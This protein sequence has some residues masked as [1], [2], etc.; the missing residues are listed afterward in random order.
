MASTGNSNNHYNNRNNNHNHNNNNRNGNAI[1][2]TSQIE[3][4]K[5]QKGNN[6][7]KYVSNCQWR[8][9]DSI[10]PDYVM[11]PSICALY[12]SVRYHK[13]NRS[14]IH[15]R[16]SKLRSKYM[17]RVLLLHIDDGENYNDDILIELNKVCCINKLT[18]ICA[19]SYLECARYIETYHY[20]K[21]KPVDCLM[22]SSYKQYVNNKRNREQNG[23]EAENKRND[24]IDTL[25]Q[26]KSVSST[27]ASTIM[28]H[29]GTIA[30]LSNCTQDELTSLPGFGNKKAK[31][32]WNAFNKPF[33][34][35][36]K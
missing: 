36:R 20:Y 23:T 17:C 2:Q 8:Y 24:V 26:I 11:S 15:G 30:A 6:L 29:F 18:L 33:K 12:L 34:T 4:S 22:S 13:M 25:T 31:N 32:L 9:N 1:I 7:L 19:W 28:N 5:R 3:V 35:D 21:N 10:I 27:N 14:Y 16:I